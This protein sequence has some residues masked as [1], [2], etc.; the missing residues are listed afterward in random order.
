MLKHL[1]IRNYALIEQLEI[2]PSGGLNIIT[3][4]TG[5]GKSI[6]L[7]A[8]GL[9]LG[10][11][12]DTNVLFD[13][14]SKCII[15]GTFDIRAY[16]LQGIFASE[17]LDYEE[18][19][20]IR[21]EIS[22][23]GKSRAFINDTPVTLD[24]LR[25]L[26]DRLM[27]IHSQHDTLLLGKSTFQ[28]DLL[29]AVA[30]ILDERKSY[31]Q[32]YSKLKF[33][34]KQ[35][36]S[37]KR[38][39]TELEKEADYRQFILEELTSASLEADELDLLEQEAEV[40]EH[41]EEIKN[42]LSAATYL[43]NEGDVPVSGA[44]Q[45]I[46]S[47]LSSLSRYSEE[48]KGYYER[49]RSLMIELDDLSNE[50]NRSAE[51]VDFDPERTILVQQRISLLYQL[52]KKHHVQ[53]IRE[54]IELRDSLDKEAV[55][56][57]ELDEEIKQV[58]E[59]TRQLL[60]EASKL[61]ADLSAK[62]KKFI[63][64]LEKEMITLLQKVGIPEASFKVTIDTV[65]LNPQGQDQVSLLFSANKGIQPQ[66]LAKVASGGEFSRLMF[67][68]KHILAEK[69]SLPTII[70][71]EIDT[72]ISG[73]IALKMGDMMKFM[74]TKHQI[75]AISHLPQMAA[76]AGK[77]YFV[78]KDNSKHVSVSRIKVLSDM[79]RVE[80]IAKMIGGDRPSENARESAR[81]L[82]GI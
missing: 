60:K 65:E 46:N 20:I 39:K 41:A 42:N 71:D 10:N 17:E 22:P 76:R 12:A 29:D 32:L 14:G 24:V 3:G 55:H 74:A 52:Q 61:A 40:M 4:E 19:T 54:L 9:L 59:E 30:S 67:C 16:D 15:E 58:E 75:I 69:I 78:Y 66:S 53:T 21:R 62:R 73:E 57:H 34:E 80:E 64:A 51:G 44:L 50:L 45:E 13:D 68:I 77:H 11:R 48:Y 27:D 6:L 49:F 36:L 33:K 8:I 82:I 25:Q 28:L 1:H 70:F 23:A 7:G 5:A 37:L 81:E 47:L 2:D 43:L 72:G 26:G 38:E 63:P 31:R 18:E 56:F 79:E 35:L